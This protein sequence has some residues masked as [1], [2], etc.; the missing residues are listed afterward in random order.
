M[1][2]TREQ[3]RERLAALE[4]ERATWDPVWRELVEYFAP[5]RGRFLEDQPNQGKKKRSKIYNGV[6]EHALRTMASGLM[7]G[8]TSPSRPWF[9]LSTWDP[10][11]AREHDVRS[12]L[13]A[14]EE[15]L[16][17][18][19]ARSNIYKA[20]SRVYAD[21]P[22]FGVSALLVLD[23]DEDVMRGYCLPV[24]SYC[25]ATDSRG[26]VDT[27]YH[28][29]TRT[30]RQLVDTFGY[31]VCSL[32][33]QRMYD[34][35]GYDQ[36]VDVLMVVEPDP[37]YEPGRIREREVTGPT[38]E[39]VRRELRASKP[40]RL[41][42]M[43][44]TDD[45]TSEFL[46]D[47]GLW[48]RPIMAPRWDVTGEDDYSD[49]PGRMA[50]SDMRA[51]QKMELRNA[52]AVEL[53]VRPPLN[54]PASLRDYGGAKTLPGEHNY[55]ADVN[56]AKI[57]PALRI[58]PRTDTL[59]HSILRHEERIRRTFYEDLFLMLAR[60]DRRQIT[61]REIEE[62]HAEKVE[63]LGPVL[64]RLNDD[65]LEPLL[66]RAF[67]VL[68]R[69][70]LVPPPPEALAGAE[71]RV[72]YI[73]PLSQ[74]QKALATTGIERTLEFIGMAAGVDPAAADVLDA[75]VAV[76]AF[77]DAVGAPPRMIREAQAV[78][79]IR[80]QRAQAQQ[81]QAA[82]EGAPPMAR[83]IKDL[84]QTPTDDGTALAELTRTLGPALAAGG[85]A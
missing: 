38:G 43:E 68:A 34:D 64:E 76:E 1:R 28:T 29:T 8:L 74:V 49:S 30:V 16:R 70:G 75:D 22:L 57:E 36:R 31:Q 33:V 24:G 52:Q 27:L 66:D 73:N 47:E 48:S 18:I 39:V 9:R 51:L 54:V 25:I 20:L 59:M 62:R 72:E 21:L 19:F 77:A 12:W 56:Q 50:L 63:A 44:L 71:L 41:T 60:N 65:L 5:M 14:V 82:A 40:W 11:L 80:Q 58:E 4:L 69:R 42:W 37:D 85:G 79:Q 83:A 6:G 13:H 10:A 55:V 2:R 61:A 17:E 78:A 26:V 15:R 35:R 84:G 7:A 46:A 53:H 67:D 45:G 23:D 32:N 3:H 81:A